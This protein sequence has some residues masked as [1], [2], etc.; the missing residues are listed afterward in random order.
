MSVRVRYSMKVQISSDP[1]TE[2]KD[3]GNIAYEIVSDDLG[4]GGARKFTV[5]AGAADYQLDLGNVANAKFLMVKT[6]ARND[7]ESPVPVTLKSAL[8]GGWS[9][10][11]APLSGAKQGHF[12]MSVA[13]LAA[14]YA[15]NP[16]A[17]DMEL[18]LAVAG[19]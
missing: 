10:I 6:N 17:V 1:T 4:D 3:L 14:L 9:I 19:D 18:T 11:V 16:G 13:G 5:A 8:V 2:S 12:L 7:L 15:D